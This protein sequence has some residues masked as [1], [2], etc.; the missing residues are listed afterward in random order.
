MMQK[1]RLQ[2]IEMN[3]TELRTELEQKCQIVIKA[4]VLVQDFKDELEKLN[5]KL[6]GLDRIQKKK[7]EEVEQTKEMEQKIAALREQHMKMK[8]KNLEQAKKESV[9]AQ[10]A[11][12]AAIMIQRCY[13]KMVQITR[14]KRQQFRI[15]VATKHVQRAWRLYNKNKQLKLFLFQLQDKFNETLLKGYNFLK[16]EFDRKANL[17]T[18][19]KQEIEERRLSEQASLVQQPE[20]AK[21]E[22]M[23]QLDQQQPFSVVEQEGAD[24]SPPQ[25]AGMER[26]LLKKPT[27]DQRMKQSQIN[28]QKRLREHLEKKYGHKWIEYHRKCKIE[29]RIFQN[30]FV[31]EICEKNQ[32]VYICRSCKLYYCTP[33]F[34]IQHK[35]HLRKNH[36]VENFQKNL[37]NQGSQKQSKPKT[38]VEQLQFIST[39][40]LAHLKDLQKYID[41]QRKLEIP[42]LEIKKFKSILINNISITQNNEQ[43]FETIMQIVNLYYVIGLP[44]VQTKYFVN[45]LETNNE[46][47][48]TDQFVEYENFIYDIQMAHKK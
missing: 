48:T 32:V 14:K 7:E 12:N 9:N 42:V 3:I 40:L 44:E 38:K 18:S 41:Y 22:E 5:L 25:K 31:C 8:Q 35:S 16:K 1:E 10:I 34:E 26:S 2:Q 23:E 17:I 47:K 33:C 29:Q 46:F 45:L 21:S 24:E 30:N 13:R 37:Q 27:L 4:K 11:V 36:L 28:A 20:E 15:K 6:L 39:Q 43:L 19:K